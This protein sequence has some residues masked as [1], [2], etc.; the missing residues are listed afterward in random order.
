[1]TLDE[2]ADTTFAQASGFL[3]GVGW[4][5]ILDTPIPVL[6]LQIKGRMDALRA[7]FGGEEEPKASDIALEPPNPEVAARQLV[8]FLER[9]M[10]GQPSG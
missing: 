1:M 2:W 8:A 10:K 6:M 9:R 3:F 5:E 4:E 7:I